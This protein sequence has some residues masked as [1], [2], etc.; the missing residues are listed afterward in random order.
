MVYVVLEEALCK[1]SSYHEVLGVFN[2][3]EKA[4]TCAQTSALDVIHDESSLF[5]DCDI[6]YPKENIVEV[7]YVDFY[8]RFTI[9]VW[10]ETSSTLILE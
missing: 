7:S 5:H 2:T 9:Q 8:D 3:L 10:D 6:T 4:Q 1:N